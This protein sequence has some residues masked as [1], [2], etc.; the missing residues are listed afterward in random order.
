MHAAYKAFEDADPGISRVMMKEDF[1]FRDVPVFKQ[2]RL[3]TVVTEEAI[4]QIADHPAYTDAYER[5]VRSF[6]GSARRG[7]LR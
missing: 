3:K 7:S 1:M 4:A 6:D 2:A 5:I